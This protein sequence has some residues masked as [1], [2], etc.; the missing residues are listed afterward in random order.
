M[1]GSRNGEMPA[2]AYELARIL[3]ACLE[4][5]IVLSVGESGAA[6][7]ELP[8]QSTPGVTPM[9]AR[10]VREASV[11]VLVRNLIGPGFELSLVRRHAETL[12][13]LT[14]YLAALSA[15]STATGY[16]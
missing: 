15:T 3:K 12:Q 13:P 10:E 11:P 4:G 9:L 2:S 5:L 7:L 8:D 16:A 6:R 1:A 14:D